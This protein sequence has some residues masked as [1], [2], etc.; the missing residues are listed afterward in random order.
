MNAFTSF[1]QK[2]R[3]LVPV[4]VVQIRDVTPCMRRISII[5]EGLRTMEVDLPAQW[6]KLF[7]PTDHDGKIG[8]AYTIR[9]FDATAGRMDIDLVLHGDEGPATRWAVNAR[10]GET[11]EVAGPRG[12]Y[13]IDAH[14]MHFTLIADATALPA[15]ASILSRLPTSSSVRII[16]EVNDARE[17]QMLKCRAPVTAHW[18]HSG[19]QAPGTSGQIAA[20]VRT[21][22]LDPIEHRVWVAGESSMVRDVRDHLM[23]DRAFA[24]GAIRS[25]GYWKLGEA[26]H[27]DRD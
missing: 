26:D 7:V 2:N 5:G 12:G 17:E 27:R 11:I 25:Q 22:A 8:R 24:R 15:A 13:E 19:R 3:T 21:L 9:D 1:K 18:L 23:K 4:E 20:F 16:I 14:A 6:V 10:L